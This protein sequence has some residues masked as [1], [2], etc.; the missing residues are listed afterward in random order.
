LVGKF[1]AEMVATL[2]PS[3]TTA[4]CPSNN[5]LRLP[6]KIPRLAVAPM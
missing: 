3:R 1:D 5:Q 2:S 6:E 4:H